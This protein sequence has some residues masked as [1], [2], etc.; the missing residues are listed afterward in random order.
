MVSFVI[1]MH[2]LSINLKIPSHFGSVFLFL[3][4]F[5]PYSVFASAIELDTTRSVVKIYTVKSQYN[6]H[7][8]WQ[9]NGIRSYQGS[10]SIISGQRI[11]TTAHVVSDQTF[12]QVRR[13]GDAKKYTAKVESIE[14]VSDLAILKVE[15]SEFFKGTI[16]L[17]IG[18]LPFVRDKVAVYGYPDGGDTLS[19]TEGVVSRIEHQEYIH[20][21]ANLLACQ[22]DAPI[23]SGNSGGPVV[24]NNKLV[25]VAFQGLYGPTTENI[26]YMVPAPIIEHFLRDIED[27]TLGGIPELG[28]SMQKM[29]NSDLRNK[30]A[31]KGN[32]TGV[33]INKIYPDSPAEGLLFTND[34]LL[35]I[36]GQTVENDGTILFR[37][38]ERTFLGYLWQ[39]KQLGDFIAVNVLRGTKRIELRIKLTKAI[40]FERVVP[41]KQY[42]TVPSYYIV[43]GL[44]FSTLT[45]N[46]LEEYGTEQNWALQAPKDL[47]S[48]YLNGEP[49][50]EQREII[51]LVNVLADDINIGYHAFTNGIVTSVNGR[52]VSNIRELADAFESNKEKFHTIEDNH[53]YRI[54]LDRLKSL[55]SNK[56]IMKRYLI[57]SDRST[58]LT[59]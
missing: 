55:Q 40:G 11:L 54:V 9:K 19:I 21:S 27:K 46:Y 49:T 32:E 53:G 22:I 13:F 41:H 58:N 29:E 33:L 7:E 44:V 14:N 4:F 24:V 36:D 56:N 34:V 51:I 1:N 52:N 39:Q 26:G 2:K 25:G 37:N 30:F 47:L 42:D 8:P 5:F 35:S 17:E 12:L 18:A 16:P 57:P 43:G 28:I 10:G 6:Y 38:E 23:N 3:L 59:K 50:R 20:S 45:R 48:Y 31:L 15:D